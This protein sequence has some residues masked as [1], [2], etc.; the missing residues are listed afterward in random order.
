MARKVFISFLGTTDYSETQYLW[1]DGTVSLPT[2]FIQ[3]AILEK[4]A[5]DWTENDRVFIFYTNQSFKKNWRDKGQKDK[6]NR[7]IKDGIH[8]IGLKTRLQNMGLKAKIRGFRMDDGHTEEQIWKIFEIVYTKLKSGD[9]IYFDMTHAFRSIPIFASTLFNFARFTKDIEVVSVHY[10]AFYESKAEIV[11]MTNIIKLQN[12]L[13]AATSITEFG[14]VPQKILKNYEDFVSHDG[15]T[16]MDTIVKGIGDLDEYIQYNRL[17]DIEK[18]SY[19]KKMLENKK[20]FDSSDAILLP[21]REV[22]NKV[23]NRVMKLKFQQQR[24]DANIMAAIEWAKEYEMFPQAYTLAREYILSRITAHFKELNPYNLDAEKDNLKKF[25]EYMSSIMGM[26]EKDVKMQY[27]QGEL[28]E[29]EEL[30]FFLLK[31]RL[32]KKMRN[33]D[34]YPKLVNYRNIINHAKGTEGYKSIKKA[35]DISFNNC[36][37]ILKNNK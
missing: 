14:R 16:M 6:N 9:K 17:R 1:A 29:Y 19:V 31:D 36:M 33:K 5:K 23:I 25:R 8:S 32:I 13:E 11:D 21:L 28:K 27:F 37:T 35:F 22:V 3:E 12:L 10:G 34:A 26:S 4:K 20:N 18:G 7:L 2:R 15:K 24:S 30:T